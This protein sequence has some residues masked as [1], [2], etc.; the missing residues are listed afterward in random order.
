MGWSQPR[1]LFHKSQ[2]FLYFETSKRWFA[3]EKKM[4]KLE[5]IEKV[6][7]KNV[8]VK[9]ERDWYPLKLTS[10]KELR[11]EV[12]LKSGQVFRWKQLQSLDQKRQSWWGVIGKQVFELK[13]ET[14]DVWFRTYPENLEASREILN[15]YFRLNISL[16]NLFEEWAKNDIK[17][18]ELEKRFFGLREI[19][20][21]PFECLF[22]FICSQNNNIGNINFAIN[23]TQLE[24]AK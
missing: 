2:S 11:L 6:E 19:R 16:S 21:D 14:D 3:I 13:E 4:I 18:I 15:D 12:T 22:S 7:E 23:I 1:P 20:Q 5:N 9:T 24:S 8:L 17:F 10:P